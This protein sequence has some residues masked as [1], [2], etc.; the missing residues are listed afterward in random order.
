MNS[1]GRSSLFHAAAA[2]A[3][4]LFAVANVTHAGIIGG[5]SASRGGPSSAILTGGEGTVLRQEVAAHFAEATFAESSYLSSTFLSSIDMLYIS[6]VYNGF[7]MVAPLDSTEQANLTAWVSNGG[8]ALLVTD[9]PAFAPTGNSMVNPF[10]LSISGSGGDGAQLGTITDHTSWPMLTDG[11]FGTVNTVHGGY[12]GSYNPGVP[13]S[14]AVLGIWNLHGLPALA[15][16][17]YGN[18]SVVFYGDESMMGDTTLLDNVLAFTLV[19]EPSTMGFVISAGIPG[20]LL[21]SRRRRLQGR[22]F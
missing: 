9:N 2:A 12:I 17:N 8:R 6:A 7:D 11:P 5:W 14:V 1:T 13:A 10:G 21:A 22:R 16:T 18:G 20:I 15:A 3:A 19:P 4:L